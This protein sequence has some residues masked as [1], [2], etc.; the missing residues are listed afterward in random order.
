VKI[1]TSAA[2]NFPRRQLA[3]R[4]AP[5]QNAKKRFYT[6]YRTALPF[7]KIVFPQQPPK[8]NKNPADKM[9][10]KRFSGDRICLHSVVHLQRAEEMA[11][12]VHGLN[13]IVNEIVS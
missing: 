5:A 2:L 13:E 3:D 1:S 10:V 8:T 12:V 11:Q 7:S 9:K 4:H 6:Q